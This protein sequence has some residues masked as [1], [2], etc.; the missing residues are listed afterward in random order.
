MRLLHQL[1]D[2]LVVERVVDQ[3][4]GTAR[5][6]QAHAA[7]QAQLMGDGG[8]ADADER[9]D[10]ADAELAAG[11]HVEDRTRV[12]SPSTLKVAASA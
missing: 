8:L 7:K 5:P 4:A 6:D 10:V 9:G 3:P 11:Q 2:V 1:H 12:G